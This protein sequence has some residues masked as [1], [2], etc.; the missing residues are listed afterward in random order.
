MVDVFE[1]VEEQL[2]SDRYRAVALKILPW[3]LGVLAAALLVALG[4]WGFDHYRTEANNKASEQYAQAIEAFDQGRAAEAESLWG[5]VAKSSS[6]GY[7]SL[8]LQHLGAAKLV[9]NQTAEAVKLFDQ[10]ADAA[11]NYVIGDV[12][13]LKSAFALLD[14]APLKDMEARLDPLTKEGRPYRTEAHE[15]LAFAKLLAGDT[16]GARGDFV[17]ISLLPDA[18]Q[19]ARDRAHAAMAL[20][21]SGSAKAVPAAVKA[22][23]ALPLPPQIAPGA[24]PAGITLPDA[25][26]QEAPNAQ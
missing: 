11:P 23:L 2:R 1:E 20:I 8:S 26:Q 19:T 3:V 7:K 16:A 5:E 25:Q 10:A 6:K 18:Q 17:V 24:V 21:D 4:L 12:A 9:A 14:T 22:A 15:A 13:R